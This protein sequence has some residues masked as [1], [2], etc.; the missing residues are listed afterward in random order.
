[1]ITQHPHFPKVQLRLHNLESKEQ[2]IVAYLVVDIFP[3]MELPQLRFI[4]SCGTRWKTAKISHPAGRPHSILALKVVFPAGENTNWCYII[5]H[6]VCLED[7]HGTPPCR[8]NGIPQLDD[9][10]DASY[11]PRKRKMFC[12][13]ENP[14]LSF[15]VAFFLS[16]ESRGWYTTVS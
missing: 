16:I 7:R 11:T 15:V 1:M 6:F 5:K 10:N 2:L 14:S 4:H 9:G 13:W 3:W 8:G 12:V